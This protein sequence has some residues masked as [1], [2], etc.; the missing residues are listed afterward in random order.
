MQADLKGAFRVMRRRPGFT[1]V[2]V[3]SLAIGIG[4]ATAVFIVLDALLFKPLPVERPER[5]VSFSV[6][7]PGDTQPRVIFPY[8]TYRQLAERLENRLALTAI[9]TVDDYDEGS[10]VRVALVSENYFAV[11]GARAAAGRLLTPADAGQPVAIVSGR[12]AKRRFGQEQ[13]A[14][15]GRQVSIKARSLTIAGVAGDGFTG[16]WVGRPVD[17]WVPISLQPQIVPE[18]PQLLTSSTRLAVRIVGRWKTGQ[19]DRP[20]V[21]GMALN[22]EDASTGYSPQRRVLLPAITLVSAVSALVLLIGVANMS[23]LL[24]LRGAAREQEIAVRV[25]LGAARGRI[26]R[27]LLI[28][29]LAVIVIGVLAAVA[30]TAFAVEG[31]ARFLARGPLAVALGPATGS[32]VDLTL[33]LDP[34]A[35]VFVAVLS[36]LMAVACGLWPAWKTSGPHTIGRV[37]LSSRMAAMRSPWLQRSVLAVQVAI[38]MVLLA[39]AAIFART[40]WNLR[41]QALGF[42]ES[43]AIVVSALPRHFG[44]DSARVMRAFTAPAR[45][46]ALPGVRAA[47]AS[48]FGLLSGTLPG[49][50]IVIPGRATMTPEEAHV[51]WNLVA[52]HYFAASGIPLLRGRDFV[53]SDSAAAPAV[54]V[55]NETAARAYFG[56][57]DAIGRRFGFKGRDVEVVGV[58]ADA[59]YRSLREPRLRLVYFPL[60]QDAG[61]VEI[62]GTM[63]A[64][65]RTEGDALAAADAVRRELHS[66]DPELPILSIRSLDEQVELSVAYE[67]ALRDLSLG[68]GALAAFLVAIG[69]YS[70]VSFVAM[71][72]TVELGIR[73]ALGATAA[74]LQR[75]LVMSEAL[76]IV[77]GV[78]LG[79]LG[80]VPIGRLLQVWVFDV[81]PADPAAIAAAVAVVVGVALT[82]C[83]L[84]ARRAARTDPVAALRSS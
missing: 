19:R 17:V 28:E 20:R 58:A 79:L 40:H 29:N 50:S 72:R 7:S 46:A 48:V 83:L 14:S 9:L 42:Q 81:S 77:S 44:R 31:L 25:S 71:S 52:P 4:S 13:T 39:A 53:D 12:Y 54:A 8:P 45:L 65:V 82:A 2:A 76:P 84:P 57:V 36:L 49:N 11:L 34:R 59:K 56:T 35:G 33:E 5:L 24:L 21:A 22:V 32:G 67:A 43:N 80:L 26:V 1:L 55:V 61:A 3:L 78:L 15:L 68:F 10:P 18:Q 63:F 66:L 38:A 47:S 64:I 74:S 37:E 73:A 70:A 69:L 60:T 16:D 75:T 62:V 6:S 51:W 27:Q 41:H 23:G 30:A